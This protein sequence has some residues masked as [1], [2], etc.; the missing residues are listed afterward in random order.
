MKSPQFWFGFTS[1]FPQTFVVM[2]G[3]SFEFQTTLSTWLSN[4]KP[5]KQ[6]FVLVIAS[7]FH[8]LLLTSQKKL[9]KLQKSCFGE[10]NNLG[11]GVKRNVKNVTLLESP[12][13]FFVNERFQACSMISC[14]SFKYLFTFSSGNLVDEITFIRYANIVSSPIN[15]ISRFIEFINLS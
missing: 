9:R 10:R 6:K 8:L 15:Q 3:K 13:N 1:K 14:T 11:N 12:P 7:M 2:P 5:M 4:A